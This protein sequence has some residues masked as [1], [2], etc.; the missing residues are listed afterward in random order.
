MCVDCGSEPAVSLL[1][2]LITGLAFVRQIREQLQSVEVTFS[3]TK[4]LFTSSNLLFRLALVYPALVFG[5][6][7]H[8]ACFAMGLV[9]TSAY[10]ST[11][12]STTTDGNVSQPGNLPTS[13]SLSLTLTPRYNLSKSFK[14]MI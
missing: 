2:L 4:M 7:K 12:A 9:N 14:S 1:P 13:P 11:N 6:F 10:A 8:C 5:E 3:P